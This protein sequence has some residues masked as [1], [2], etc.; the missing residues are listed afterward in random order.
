MNKFI[1][2]GYNDDLISVEG[3]T[4]KEFYANYTKPTIISVG[5]CKIKAE[6]NLQGEWIFEFLNM[7][8]NAK[9]TYYSVGEY[10]DAPEHSSAVVI[11]T[12]ED[13]EVE[14]L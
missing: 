7:P 13:V 11:E 3:D 9:W 10:K 14:K 1:I 8:G 5:E 6:Y 4:H 2:F 12:E